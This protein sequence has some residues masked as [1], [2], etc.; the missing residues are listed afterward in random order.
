MFIYLGNKLC[1]PLNAERV[2]MPPARG[3]DT[4]A[5]RRVLLGSIGVLCQ[6][7]E[8]SENLVGRI[9]MRRRI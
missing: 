2:G 3:S 8:A 4:T 1:V 7:L 6:V 9:R 5:C